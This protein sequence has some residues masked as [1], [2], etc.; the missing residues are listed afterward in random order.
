MYR[1]Q[2]S[3]RDFLESTL[4]A[5]AVLPVGAL[6]SASAQKALGIEAQGRTD[7]KLPSL[8]DA[9][10][11]E[12][13]SHADLDY[14]QP[15]T[16]SEEGQPI[17]NGRMG[18]LV[19]TTPASLK[20]QINRVD[21]FAENCETNSFPERHTDYGS[22][23][24]YVDIDCSSFGDE[25]FTGTDFNQHLHVYD[26]MMTLSANQVTIRALAQADSDVIAVEIDD[27]RGQPMPITVDLRMLRYMIQYIEGKNYALENSHSVA[28]VTRNQT[29]TSALGTAKSR[30]TLKQEF[31]E[32]DYY[33]ASAIAIEAIGRRAKASYANESTVRLS[34]PPGRGKVTVLI[35][36]AASFDP[37]EDSS[38][39]EFRF[40]RRGAQEMVALLLV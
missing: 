9:D 18:S 13:V 6:L 15:V 12:I 1:T 14:T 22:G 10:F 31:R 38:R 30:I 33:N 7:A 39:T 3:R 5:G 35:G 37:K 36:S 20:F 34:L 28:V 16:R 11:R 32:G 23:C 2:Y 24:G 4:K 40:I 26:G 25:V 27:K 29:A 8:I 17:G 21:V 19:W